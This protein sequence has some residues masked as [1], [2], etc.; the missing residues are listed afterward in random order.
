MLKMNSYIV[1]RRQTKKEIT[2]FPSL[3]VHF[4]SFFTY[5]FLIFQLITANA[6]TK[7]DPGFGLEA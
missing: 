3:T 4:V 6:Y 1:I 5:F 7:S 2:H